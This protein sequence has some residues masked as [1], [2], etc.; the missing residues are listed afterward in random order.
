MKIERERER[1]ECQLALV[2]IPDQ[3]HNSFMADAEGALAADQ[4]TNAV[5]S[6]ETDAGQ[7]GS[8]AAVCW[9]F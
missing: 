6:A 1:L 8:N 9:V 7:Q 2:V 4:G 5:T 3:R